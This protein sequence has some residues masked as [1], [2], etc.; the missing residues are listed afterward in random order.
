MQDLEIILPRH[1]LLKLIRDLDSIE[2][3]LILVNRET[4]TT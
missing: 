4:L 1:H 2:R 3:R